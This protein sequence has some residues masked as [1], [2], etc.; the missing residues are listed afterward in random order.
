[1][2][3]RY[4]RTNPKTKH[5]RRVIACVCIFVSPSGKY[6]TK[7]QTH[8]S[9]NKASSSSHRV[10]LYF[11]KPIWQICYK[12]TNAP[13]RKKSNASSCHFVRLYFCKPIWQI[14][15]KDTNASSRQKA[16]HR[17]VIACVF[18]VAIHVVNNICEK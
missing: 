3:Q 2:L 1:M 5:R 16:T 10:R 15:Y 6:V 18:F 14:C 13:I 17:H 11:C 8:Q 4:K 12:D 7:I 9:E